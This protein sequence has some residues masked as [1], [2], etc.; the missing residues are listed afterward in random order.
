MMRRVVK[1]SAFSLIE[2]VV[3]LATILIL[4]GAMLGVGR[5]LTIRA[6][7]DLTASELQVLTTALQQYYDD[8]EVFPIITEKDITGDGVIDPYDEFHLE[9]DFNGTVVPDN[10]IDNLDAAAA[11]SAAMFYFLRQNPNSRTIINAMT[12]SL[13]TNNGVSGVNLQITL[14]SG[15]IDL[16]RF[17]DAWGTSIRY[18]YTGGTAFPI[19]SSAGPD[20]QF[21]TPDDVTSQ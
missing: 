2:M 4:A 8:F 17:I 7:I 3:V 13:V 20:E 11:S 6:N 16:P 1:Q 19:L 18:E 5:Y 21:G 10:A 9:Y 14:L 15:Q 12:D